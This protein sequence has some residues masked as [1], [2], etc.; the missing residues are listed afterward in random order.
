MIFTPS[1]ALMTIWHSDAFPA[2]GPTLSSEDGT[3][4]LNPV[5]AV[6]SVVNWK[7][8][9]PCSDETAEQGMPNVP[10]S[11]GLGWISGEI[12]A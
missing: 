9:S 11:A 12:S 6:S 10:S 8:I 2:K 5:F 4:R 7:V 1:N 3:V